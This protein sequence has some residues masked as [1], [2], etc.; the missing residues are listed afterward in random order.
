MI[1]LEKTTREKQGQGSGQA[2]GAKN[3]YGGSN[4]KASS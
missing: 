3:P 4:L 2:L 1:A